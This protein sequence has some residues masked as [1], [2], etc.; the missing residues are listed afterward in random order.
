MNRQS[1]RERYCARTLDLR[2]Y[3]LEGLESRLLLA[4]LASTSPY[5][6]Q[7]NVAIGANLSVTF[8]SAM[9]PASL[10]GS[11][12]RLTDASGVTLATSLSY[13]ATTRTLTVDPAQSLPLGNSYLSLRI[14]GGTDG[15]RGSD[16]STLPQDHVSRFTTGAP[17]F[18]EVN[19][20]TGLVNPTA[21]EFAADGRVF[22]AEKR[23]IIK[24]F[25]SLTDSTPDVFADLR[26]QVHNFWDRGLLGLTLDPQFTTGR[27]YVYVLYTYDGDIG[28]SAPK[29]G[30][31]NGDD[32]PGNNSGTS[33]VSGRLT[34]LTASGNAMVGSERVLV[35]DWQNQFPS[36]SIGDLAFGP[37]GFLYASAG[38]GASFNG[39]DYGQFGNPF[40]DPANQGGALRSQDLLSSGD[41]QSLDGTVIRIDPETGAAA[42]GNPH[43]AN[44]DANAKRIIAT[45]LR[46]PFR[47]VFRPGTSEIW[48]AETGWNTFEEINRIAS[49]SDSTSEN[50]GWPAYEGPSRQS[51]YDG[52]N[53]PLLEDLYAA[54]TGAV[55]A[56]WFHYAHSERVVPGSAEPTGGSTPSG[57]AFY[58]GN[59]Y[60][61]AYADA[62]FF[63][64]YARKQIYI[65]YRGVDGTP[66]PSSRQIFRS[67]GS[68]AVDLVVGPDGA[69][70]YADLAGNRVVR[71]DYADAASAND[72]LPGTVIGTTGS[73]NNLGNTREKAFDSDLSTYFDAPTADGSWVGLDLGSARWVRTIQ[74]APRAGQAA[75]MVGGVFQGSNDASFSSGVVN[76][77]TIASAPPA[78]V[79]TTLSVNPTGQSFRY[80]RYLGPTGGFGNVAEIRFYAGDGLAATYHDNIDFSGSTVSRVDKSI[81]FNWGSG[82][83]DAAIGADTFSA[84][85]TGR[86]QA[87]EAG[88]YTFRTT[89]DDGVRLW[90]NNQLLIDRFVDQSATSHTGSI[91]L[92]AGQ[93]YDIRI[94]YYENGGDASMKLEWQRPGRPMEPVPMHSL[95]SVSASTNQP[96]VPS[97]H[98]PT[99]ALNWKVGDTISFAGGATDPEDGALGAASLQWQLV[100]VHGNE[101]DP[102]NAHEHVITNLNGVATGSF[103]APDHEYPS[104]LIIR[105]TATDSQGLSASQ[106]L[107]V[108]PRTTVL[109][110]ASSPSGLKVAFN[111]TEYATPFSRTVITSSASSVAAISPQVLGAVG[112]GFVSWA[113]GGNA[114]QS[115]VAPFNNTT[116]TATYTSAPI[117]PTALAAVALGTSSI[118]LSWT[119]NATNET[120]YNIER[121]TGTAGT[122]SQIGIRGPN[123]ANFVDEG[124]AAGME[125]HYRVYASNAAGPSGYSNVAV[126]STNGTSSLP[127]APTALSATVLAGPQ[128]RLTWTDNAGNET[129]YIV[130]RRYAGW[131]WEDL[132]VAGANAV[133]HLDTTSIGNVVYEYR[134]AA[135]NAVGTSPWSSGVLVNTANVG[136]QPPT[137]P[138]ALTANAPGA[139]R[140]DLAWSDNSTT[141]TGFHVERRV[142]GGTFARIATTASNATLY[143]DTSVVAGTSYEYRVIATTGA[144]DSTPSNTATVTTPGGV[145]VPNTPTGFGLVVNANRSVSLSWN[146]NSTNETGFRIQR[147]YRGWIWEDLATVGPGATSYLDSATI[148]GVVYEYRIVALGAGG[149]APPTNAL[150][151]VIP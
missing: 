58:T 49:A 103:V 7:Q 132:T 95:F 126:A 118:S 116:Y 16:N 13:N 139:N 85:W 6:G 101:I 121:R 144:V 98:S 114:S 92:A 82:S 67:L 142:V 91:A 140:V 133:T 73:Y 90:V 53:L 147:R 125:Y 129:G 87:I 11:T 108:D 136:V 30:T 113:H 32:D 148:R 50:F 109:S 3:R 105:L 79:F 15:V 74:F 119:D 24:V 29:W 145:G 65:M 104:W 78:G 25:D 46:N 48:I 71:I 117:A 134:V 83:P 12:I 59:A 94:D 44:P 36:H 124:L 81:D 149:N 146:D 128:V 93:L 47:F 9:N 62:M 52:A 54:G 57:I 99:I 51:G 20:F 75:R 42:P 2:R 150:E 100:L 135:R 26:T 19:A 141:E 115:L 120:Q 27:P 127:D 123:A 122:W 8:T 66:D 138:S 56:P 151:A 14:V 38:D 110:F 23:G 97:I 4:S 76:L 77:A 39:V 22:V 41:P 64:D 89:S 130:Q 102:N 40:N 137:A 55:S 107:R 18:N 17:V 63:T 1:S 37:D 106:S 88:S 21:I 131:I 45:G 69:L 31:A 80:V 5:H 86:I 84:R 143:A 111:G 10:T 28:G 68:G 60:P 61:S 33:T 112:Y 43:A 96:P 72:S 34:R 70:Y 35:H